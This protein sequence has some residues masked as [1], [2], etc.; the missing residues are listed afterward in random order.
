MGDKF[1]K[2][3]K[4]A[5]VAKG[6]E[7]EGVTLTQAFCP[8]SRRK[9][10]KLLADSCYDYHPD[11]DDVEQARA[12]GVRPRNNIE[13]TVV[14]V[15]YKVTRGEP[16]YVYETG[17]KGLWPLIK[18]GALPGDEWRWTTGDASSNEVHHYKY[19][20]AVRCGGHDCVLIIC[21]IG[22]E[23]VGIVFR[24]ETWYARNVGLVKRDDYVVIKT[25]IHACTE[26]LIGE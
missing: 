19:A 5:D 24:H 18:L 1:Y 17:E 2:G 9:Y 4:F 21:E 15:R 13:E 25:W 3:L 22:N 26:Y 14:D 10:R 20:K 8:D 12:L 23:R 7:I 6:G 11:P 16:K